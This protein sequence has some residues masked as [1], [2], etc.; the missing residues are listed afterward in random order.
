[1]FTLL[2]I[3]TITLGFLGKVV[4]KSI[5]TKNTL[6]GTRFNPSQPS[7]VLITVIVLRLFYIYLKTLIAL[8]AT[9]FTIM[10][11]KWIVPDTIANTC[12]IK[13]C[14]INVMINQTI[15]LQI[16]IGWISFTFKAASLIVCYSQ[17]LGLKDAL[18]DFQ[19][20]INSI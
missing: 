9:I 11:K 15:I 20:A 19:F 3:N 16:S 8:Y 17:K 1:M 2:Q 6:H 5:L 12:T 7:K 4:L 14:T 18:I 13:Y 10:N